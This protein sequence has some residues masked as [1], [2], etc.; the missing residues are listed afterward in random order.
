MHRALI[1]ILLVAFGVA[2]QPKEPTSAPPPEATPSPTRYDVVVYTAHPDDEAMYAGGTM[3]RLV[4]KGHRVI[5][6]S[7]T[8]GEGGRLL[9]RGADGKIV[10]RRDLPRSEVVRV[11]DRE[12]AD[13]ARSINVSFAHLR[14]AEENLDFAFTTSTEDT[15]A[16]W[17][18]DSIVHS[19]V[20]DMN[21]RRPRIVITL[22]PRDDPQGSN[23]G[24]HKAMGLLVAQAAHTSG[25]VD[26][27]WSMAPRGT[28]A[29]L[30]VPVRVEARL[31]M[32]R[33]YPSQFIADDLAKDPIATR[34]TESF[35]LLWKVGAGRELLP[36]LVR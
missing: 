21:T 16:R 18:V 24:H 22:D 14:R 5:F 28:A 3:D 12:I 31:A 29:T 10:E 26:E 11:R 8:H 32:L 9:Q 7:L 13:A 6:V 35:V 36:E 4:K 23:H 20:D 27:L 1:L 34:P 17:P 30:D 33:A 19:L 15:L 2:C 25:A